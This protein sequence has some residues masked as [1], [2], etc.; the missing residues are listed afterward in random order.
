MTLYVAEC[1]LPDYMVGLS[2]LYNSSHIHKYRV[3]MMV[4]MMVVIMTSII[5]TIMVMV[6]IAGT[7]SI[8]VG[9]KNSAQRRGSKWRRGSCTLENPTSFSILTISVLFVLR[10]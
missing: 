5:V 9:Q 10:D 4:K 3:L 7:V 8:R 2:Q 1:L 6:C